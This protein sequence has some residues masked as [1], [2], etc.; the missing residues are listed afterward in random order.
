VPKVA[1]G[2]KT[3]PKAAANTTPPGTPTGGN[4]LPPGAVMPPQAPLRGD[5]LDK[6]NNLRVD[7]SQFQFTTTPARGA[8][9][10]GEEV[11]CSARVGAN[12]YLIVL[13]RDTEGKVVV[14][15]PESGKPDDARVTA[16][17]TVA[18]PGENQAFVPEVTG[19]HWLKA[20]FVPTKE[21]AELVLKKPHGLFPD[22]G[23]RDIIRVPKGSQPGF[24]AHVGFVVKQ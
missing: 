7:R 16:G 4:P 24:V 9:S 13:E 15:F 18:I 5:E 23:R 11:S 19:N 3:P 22:A 2:P 6:Q 12:G 17:Q 14:L 8:L 21:Q 10:A 1:P 20:V